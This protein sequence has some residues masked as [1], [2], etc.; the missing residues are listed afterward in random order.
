MR[1]TLFLGNPSSDEV[2]TDQKKFLQVA[3][4]HSIR[5]VDL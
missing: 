3:I 4:T 1:V 2:V 5:L